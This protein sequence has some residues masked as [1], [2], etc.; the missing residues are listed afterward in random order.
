MAAFL[1]VPSMFNSL[2]VEVLSH[3]DYSVP[4]CLLDSLGLPRVFAG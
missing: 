1:C 3:H 2:E 4:Y